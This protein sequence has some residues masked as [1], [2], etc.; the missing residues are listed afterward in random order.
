MHVLTHGSHVLKHAFILHVP[1]K[2]ILILTVLHSSNS[3]FSLIYYLRDTAVIRQ[4]A[5]YYN[6]VTCYPLDR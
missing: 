4:N 5:T 2:L 6:N 1:V 3:V